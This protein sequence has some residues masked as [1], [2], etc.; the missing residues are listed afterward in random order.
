MT[1]KDADSQRHLRPQDHLHVHE[2][3]ISW[4]QGLEPEVTQ[5]EGQDDLDFG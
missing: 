3:A 4:L 1:T 2:D 5:K